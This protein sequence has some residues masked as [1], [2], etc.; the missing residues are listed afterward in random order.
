MQK[1]L[2]NINLYNINWFIT[3]I[4]DWNGKKDKWYVKANKEKFLD[5][6]KYT[7][8]FQLWFHTKKTNDRVINSSVTKTQLENCF[9]FFK[10]QAIKF[11][12]KNLECKKS[13]EKWKVNETIRNLNI[14]NREIEIKQENLKIEIKNL[15][16]NIL[17]LESQKISKFKNI[18]LKIITFGFY[19]KNKKINVKKNQFEILK[20]K[21]N[22]DINK[23]AEDFH[24]NSRIISNNNE[25]KIKYK[26]QYDNNIVLA[27]NTILDFEK[28]LLLIQTEKENIISN[29]ISRKESLDSGISDY[30]EEG[31]DTLKYFKEKEINSIE[32]YNQPSTTSANTNSLYV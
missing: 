28:I 12:D 22:I 1:E 30:F 10:N 2:D 14:K 26:K 17:F 11:K 15:N 9:T 19:D 27:N 25:F 23:Y 7:T 24:N 8:I 18:L 6:E 29:K 4:L 16:K 32:Y 5:E 21:I 3:E 13:I 31:I 20:E